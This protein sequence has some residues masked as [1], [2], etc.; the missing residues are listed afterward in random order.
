MGM[1]LNFSIAFHPQT[2]GQS[3]RT[4]QILEDML[5]ACVLEFKGSWVQY[6]PLIKFAYNNS[7]QATIRMPPYEALYGRKCQSPLY[8][9]NIGERQTLGLELIQDTCEKVRVI[10]ERMSAAQNRQKSYT[11]KRK[12]PLEFEVGDRVFLKVSP[13]REVM[14]F[15]KKGKLNPRFIGP[16]EIAQKVGKLAY[17]IAL[18]PDLIGTHDVFHVSMLRK[19]IAN[20]KVIVEY[21]PLGIQE[22]LTYMEEPVK[23]VDKKEQVLRTKM[24]PIVKVLW[25]NHGVEEASWEAEHNMRSRYPHLFK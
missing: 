14:R 7:Y 6:L 2:D 20:P 8:W 22:G 10:K 25:H 4:N 11:D 21:K 18:P 3:E 23:I 1:E 5:R 19:Y 9:D 12:R 15:G 13:M 16:F 24:I 17:R